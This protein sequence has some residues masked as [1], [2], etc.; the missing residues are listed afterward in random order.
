MRIRD[1]VRLSWGVL[2]VL[3]D[4]RELRL[5]QFARLT[6]V[7]G[8]W[9]YTVTFAVFAYRAS[10][11]AGVAIAGIVRLG[12]AAAAAPFAG[13]LIARFRLD[14]LLFR[15][16][17]VRTAALAAA[18]CVILAGAAS[19]W[20]YALVAVESS[21]STLMRPAQNSLV[22]ELAR[23]PRELTSANLA[24]SVI[25]SAGVFMGPLL[26]ALL[27]HTIDLGAVFIVSAGAYLVSALLLLPIKTRP[28]ARTVESGHAGLL[29]EAAAGIR[30]MTADR[31]VAVIVF[32]YGAQN[33]VAG[34]L[35][36]LIVVIALRLLELGPSGVGALTAAVGVGGVIGGALVFARLRRGRHGADLGLGLLLWGIPLIMLALN[37]SQAAALVLLGVVGVGVTV[38]DVSTVTLLQRSASDESLAHAFGL[39]QTVFVVGIATGTLLAPFLVSSVGVRGAVLITGALL[40]LLAAALWPRVRRLD[41]LDVANPA[42]VALLAAIPIFEPL[43]EAAL[44]HLA[45][46]LVPSI[47][48]AGETVFEQGDR[49]DAFYVIESGT[50]AVVVDGSDV[51]ILGSGGYFG[52]IALLR[53]VPR[54][55]TIV[56]RTEAQLLRLDR[57]PFLATVMGNATSSRNADAIVANRLGLRA[58]LASF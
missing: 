11:T 22:P 52:E 51:A 55:A 42:L 43:P 46:A 23:T 25:E 47:A 50:A 29:V 13:S 40:P 10:G 44:E 9:A 34:A 58:G 12:P 41:S 33:L 35:N 53:D 31:N 6:S 39:L 32:L 8:R 30:A 18:G 45:N 37:S 19:W 17:L 38:V 16:G 1:R 2:R 4:N 21:V 27:L 48:A 57:D 3:A 28:T 36:V 15:G 20:V 5:V 24:L 26:G 14:A 49:G 56:V 54:T 7:T